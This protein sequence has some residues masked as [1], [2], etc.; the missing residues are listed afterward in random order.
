MAGYVG[1]QAFGSFADPL[2]LGETLL[3][4]PVSVATRHERAGEEGNV[5]VPTRCS[6]SA[7]VRRPS[8]AWVPCRSA[9]TAEGSPVG[10][11]RR[12]R[13]SSPPFKHAIQ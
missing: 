5:T 4:G 1:L 10:R 11:A 8:T 12:R 7:P 2:D 13:G 3:D 9:K 6:T